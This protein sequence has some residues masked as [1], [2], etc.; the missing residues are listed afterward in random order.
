MMLFLVVIE[1]MLQALSS[2]SLGYLYLPVQSVKAKHKILEIS[3]THQK[4]FNLRFPTI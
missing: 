3:P 2:L 1:G 4:S